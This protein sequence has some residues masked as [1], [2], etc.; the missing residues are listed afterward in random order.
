MT[1]RRWVA[2]GLAGFLL[3]LVA[4]ITTLAGTAAG[5]RWLVAKAALYLPDALT[6]DEVDGTLLQGLRAGRIAWDDDAVNLQASQV[7]VDVEWLP[8]LSRDI[9]LTGL[10]VDSLAVTIS[11]GTEPTDEPSPP[12]I[13]LPVRLELMDA[14]I[15][16]I[17][18]TAD[19]QQRQIEDFRFSGELGGERLQ[20]TALALQSQGL[21]IETSG[22]LQLAPP[23]S[24]DLEGRWR[25][26]P[27]EGQA[28]SGEGS[29]SGDWRAYDLEHRLDE[30]FAVA[31][32]GEID[33]ENF[34]PV[35][36]VTN[37]WER[38]ETDLDGRRVLSTD[39]RLQVDGNQE[40][41]DVEFSSALEID[42]LPAAETTLD[43]SGTLQGLDI[44]EATITAEP[45]S[46][47][48]GGRVTWEPRLNW[49]LDIDL[50]RLD[51]AWVNDQLAGE[52]N[53]RVLLEGELPAGESVDLDVDVSALEGSLNGWPVTGRSQVSLRA[54]RVGEVSGDFAVGDNEL[55]LEGV[56]EPEL[57]LRLS[58]DARALGEIAPQADG[59]LTAE[60]SLAGPHDDP[61]LEARIR[62][63]R[64]SWDERVGEDLAI[65]L[66]GRRGQHQVSVAGSVR[67]VRL[68]SEAAGRLV[69]DAWNGELRRMTL[70]GEPLGQWQLEQ[71]ASLAASA[72]EVSATGFCVARRDLAGEL[73]FDADYV[74][75]ESLARVSFDGRGVPL[76]AFVAGVSDEV[77]ARG[78]LRASGEANIGGG[79]LDGRLEIGI[80]NGGLSAQY[81]GDLTTTDFEQAMLSAS[82]DDGRLAGEANLVLGDGLGQL[83]ARVGADDLRDPATAIDG[84]LEMAIDELTAFALIIPEVSQPSGA[85]NGTL[86][87]GGTAADPEFRGVLAVTDGRFAI[88]AA[89]ITVEALNVELAQS[90]LDE[91]TIKGNARSGEGEIAIDGR[92]SFRAAT[93]VVT[94]VTVTGDNVELL[95]LPDREITASPDLR[96]EFDDRRVALTGTIFVPY[97]NIVVNEVPE[98]AESA[99]PDAVVHREDARPDEQRRYSI[100]V[101]TELGDAVHIEGFGLTTDLEGSLRVL[102]SSDAV[103][104]GEGRLGLLNG[105]FQAYGQDLRIERGEL[106]F[107]GPLNSPELDIRAI[108][109]AGE[110]TAGVQLNGPPDQLRST[111]FSEPAMSDAEALAY[112][113]TG[114]PLSTASTGEGNRLNEAA[115][116]LGLSRAG[117]VTSQIQNTLGLDSLTLEGGA[118]SGRIV[119]GRRLGGRLFVE[120]GYGLVDQLGTLLLRLQLT[121]R[122]V[123]ESSSGSRHTL[124]I[125]YSV[126][127]E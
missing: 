56:V 30:P 123:V 50:L 1:W 63:P 42:G 101:R 4:G 55:R 80:D 13:D 76:A 65:D 107:N 66:A 5:T 122:I 121:D 106:L 18:I 38:I 78:T 35:V 75:A 93:G 15:N 54:G 49:R 102:S 12:E 125:V 34:E 103:L 44:R 69:D 59:L 3:V 47:T 79:R 2:F 83:S 84:Y 21:S 57:D 19:G 41:F 109:D 8:L 10:T 25:W 73:C 48:A 82:L 6:I 70:E 39:G 77:E 127:R 115:F 100:D 97:A 60:A 20:M 87:V 68:V 16:A 74:V 112:L 96:L 53:A 118:D 26:Q 91:L 46:L 120:Y 22:S 52:L 117:A 71:P 89:G 62:A 86:E 29:L 124:N 81:E 9:R 17:E 90:R 108:R 92:T 37:Q 94:E 104:Q 32:L 11:P 31:S 36:N 114:R 40:R 99:S 85:I 111:V 58:V 23:Y 43:G 72:N 61:R 98:T 110:V 116:A 27:D 14:R 88:P 7:L 105:R 119:A 67:G 33:L 95:R 64:V 126:T 45:V 113:L 24:G 51:P 28:F